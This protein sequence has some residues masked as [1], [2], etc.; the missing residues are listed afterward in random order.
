MSAPSF[1][2]YAD[3]AN[4]GAYANAERNLSNA[5]AIGQT[6]Q[7]QWGVNFDSKNSGGGKGIDLY[8]GTNQIL[9][10]HMGDSEKITVAGSDTG[11]TYGSRAMTW[12]FTRI[13]SNSIFISATPRNPA[14]VTSFTTNINV[15]SGALDRFKFYAYG[16]DADTS[17]NRK[18]YFNNFL[19]TSAD[20]LPPT[21]SLQGDKFV[22]VAVGGTY[23]P[24]SP[25]VTVSDNVTAATNIIVTTNSLD[26]SVAGLQT[27]IYTAKD[28]ANNTASITRVVL[29]GDLTPATTDTYYY[30]KYPS[31]LTYNPTNTG[32]VY[33]QIYIKGATEGLGQAPNIRAWIGVSSNN[34]DPSVWGDSV[35]KVASYNSGQIGNNDEYSVQISGSNYPTGNTYYYAT[36]WQVGSGAYAY[37]GTNGP[38]NSTTSGSGSLSM[39]NTF[40]S[41]SRGASLNAENLGKYA[42]GGASSLAA[43]GEAPNVGTG[44]IVPNH[45]SSIEAVVRTDDAGLQIVPE[46]TSDLVAGFNTNGIWTTE[47]KST[48]SQTGVPSGCERKRFILWHGMAEERK[49]LRLKTTLQP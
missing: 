47:G 31:T 45:Y 48:V 21:I 7:F 20:V 41:W 15:A 44:L 36:R 5:L 2:L 46:S 37:G 24:P 43:Q 40:D 35:W 12:S 49:F 34:T 9:N 32:T 25:A 27:I 18:P 39:V 10:I 13:S 22:Q 6:L 42:I 29:V 26:T 23:M 8:S 33:G 30:L 4:S 16:L 3:P 11:F 28:E 38:W 19:I 17:A 1:S 14:N